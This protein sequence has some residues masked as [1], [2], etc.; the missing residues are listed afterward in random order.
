MEG[1]IR[2]DKSRSEERDTTEHPLSHMIYLRSRH[3]R[4]L[5]RV[6]YT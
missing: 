1:V 6:T 3:L 4:K 5:W 2:E